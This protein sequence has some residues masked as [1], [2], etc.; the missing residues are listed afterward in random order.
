MSIQEQVDRLID[1]RPGKELLSFA[2]D[3]RAFRIN[4]FIHR[5]SGTSASYLLVASAGRVIVNTG[6]GWEAPH[7]KH[8]FDAIC[9]GPTP[10][11]ITTQG[12][13]DH[14]GGV[15]LFREP[16][17]RYVAQAMNQACQAY[18]ARI[19][20][21]RSGPSTM[22][23]HLALS[24]LPDWAAGSEL[25]RFAYVHLAPSLEAMSVTYTQAM[26]GLLPPPSARVDQAE[27]AAWTVVANV[28]LNLDEAITK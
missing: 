19:A 6:M 7:H 25:K 4:E 20:R 9:P 11:V 16:G 8:L 12:H 18:D 23:I 2:H 27:L 13:V 1:T 15:A 24:D 22:M 26:A 21:F 10:Y 17:T 5:S 28:L 14:V 3:E